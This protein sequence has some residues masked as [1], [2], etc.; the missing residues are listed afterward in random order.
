[1]NTV[2]SWDGEND[3]DVVGLLSSSLA[4]SISDIPWEGPIAAVRVGRINNEFVLNPTYKEREESEIDLIFAGCEDGKDV[5]IN[6]I[7]GGLKEVEES[8]VLW[9]ALDFAK[10]YLKN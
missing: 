6:M 5:L 9:G 2:L 8:I 1:M 3:P 10:K 7:E 4:L